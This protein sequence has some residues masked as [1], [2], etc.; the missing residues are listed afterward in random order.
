M[1]DL[2]SNKIKNLLP[3]GVSAGAL[4]SLRLANLLSLNLSDNP[5]KDLRV[6]TDYIASVM[7]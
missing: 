4:T 2:S 5:I 7:P 6:T 3:P 1:L